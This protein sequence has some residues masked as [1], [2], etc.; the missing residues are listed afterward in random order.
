VRLLGIERHA[1]RDR[2]TVVPDSAAGLRR[3]LF[4]LKKRPE[5]RVTYAVPGEDSD[6]I[7]AVTVQIEVTGC[8]ATA[9]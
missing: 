7:D 1:G 2:A 8:A 9:V 5:G 4:A 6:G 3:L